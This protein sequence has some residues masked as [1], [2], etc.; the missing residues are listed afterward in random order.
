[1]R[2]VKKKGEKR[3]SIL[4]LTAARIPKEVASKKEKGTSGRTVVVERAEDARG[5]L[6]MFD[7]CYENSA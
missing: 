6:L 2:T 4:R 1:M 5:T 7:R 3:T